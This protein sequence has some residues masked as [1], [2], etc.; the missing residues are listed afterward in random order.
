[1]CNLKA[2]GWISFFGILGVVIVLRAII[3]VPDVRA[4]QAPMTRIVGSHFDLNEFIVRRVIERF[5]RDPN[6]TSEDVGA[7][8]K[9]DVAAGVRAIYNRGFREDDLVEC[10]KVFENLSSLDDAQTVAVA[11]AYKKWQGAHPE[12]FTKS[13]KAI[14]TKVLAKMLQL[15]NGNDAK[16]QVQACIDYPEGESTT[17]KGSVPDAYELKGEKG[18]R[19]SS[20][21][22]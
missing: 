13:H 18:S 16:K 2:L 20:D 21:D 7:L 17:D 11:E 10:A 5:A 4:E 6:T 15:A 1:M 3:T 19:N 22:K 8:S 12:L 14:Q 9:Y